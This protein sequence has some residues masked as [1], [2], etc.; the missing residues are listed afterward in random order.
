V[1]SQGLPE[2]LEAAPIARRA[3]DWIAQG[4]AP[5]ASEVA[6]IYD[7]ATDTARKVEPTGP[8]EYGAIGPTEIPTTLDLVWIHD[9]D[10]ITIRDLKTGKKPAHMEQLYIQALAA[11]RLYG[12]QRAR[13][14]FLWARRTKC[15][16]DPLED[17][18]PGELEAESWRAASVLRRLPVA[19]PVSGDACWFC[20]ARPQCPAHDTTPERTTTEMTT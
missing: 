13:V 12:K 9:D 3:L 20:P 15:E 5:Y 11:T 2:E 18:G 14:G 6:I 10:T 7:A 1:P 16:A 8:R 17:L 19:Q 4:P